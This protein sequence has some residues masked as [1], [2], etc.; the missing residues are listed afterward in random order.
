MVEYIN[1]WVKKSM[2]F[3]GN[4]KVV[5]SLIAIAIL[6]VLAFIAHLI[7]RQLLLRLVKKLATRTKAQWDDALVKHHFFD[8]L[9]QIAPGLILYLTIPTALEYAPELASFASK[10]AMLY[11][12]L[13]GILAFDAFL[14]A[15]QHVYRT[16]DVARSVSITSFLQIL[17]VLSYALALILTISILLEKSPT[18]ILAGL[19]AMSAVTMLVF[20]DAIL[21]FVAG[22]QLSANRMVAA[23]D[24]IEVPSHG[25]DGDVVQ[26]GLTTVKIRN[27][28]NTIST[29]PTHALITDT[30]KNWRGMSESGGRRIKRS[31]KLDMTS[32]KFCTQEMLERFEKIAFIREHLKGKRDEVA[33]HNHDSKVDHDCLVNG[34]RL[35]NLG[36]FR[37][38]VEAYLKNHPQISQDLTFLVRQLAPSE[39]GIAIEI[40]VFSKDKRWIP[41]EGI[42][43]DIFDHLLAVIPE[44]DLRV[45]QS[46]T[47]NDMRT[48]LTG[49]NPPSDPPNTR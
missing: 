12:L 2:A 9:A 46:P 32:V 41:Y 1:T 31:I 10:L 47:G 28:D 37:A 15:A 18:G 13:I 21:G 25:I 35:T 39:T 44:F 5:A 11:M 23:G 17:K 34:R 43:A 40:Y 20:K 19:G 6:C 3:G 27:F 22:L 33:K 29:L 48:G 49:T 7:A 16:H 14:N 30:F 8:R 42:Q 36:T 4:S 26:V 45:F 24:W 38:Y